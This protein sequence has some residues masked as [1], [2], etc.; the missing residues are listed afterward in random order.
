MH[1]LVIHKSGKVINKLE[2]WQDRKWAGDAGDRI[3]SCLFDLCPHIV[4]H[5]DLL[6]GRQTLYLICT[7]QEIQSPVNQI[8]KV[9]I[10]NI[11]DIRRVT[12][13]RAKSYHLKEVWKEKQKAHTSEG[14][15]R[16]FTPCYDHLQSCAH[17]VKTVFLVWFYISSFLCTLW[18]PIAQT[19]F[20]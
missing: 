15:K 1:I 12:I 16:L 6:R 18:E 17:T 7:R 14:M 13:Y 5:L 9:L 3:W 4:R 19:W 11:K 2:V 20:T 10:E 8:L